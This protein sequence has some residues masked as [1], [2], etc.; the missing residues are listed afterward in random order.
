MTMRVNGEAPSAYAAAK[1]TN[2][3]AAQKNDVAQTER[4]EAP[5]YR[6]EISARGR[7]ESDGEYI[8]RL[9]SSTKRYDGEIKAGSMEEFYTSWRAKQKELTERAAEKN[10]AVLILPE[11]YSDELYWKGDQILGINIYAEHWTEKKGVENPLYAEADERFESY[12]SVIDKVRAGGASAFR[13]YNLK[14]AGMAALANNAYADEELGKRIA[15]GHTTVEEYTRAKSYANEL[16]N[17]AGVFVAVDF[18]SPSTRFA[19]RIRYEYNGSLANIGVKE[20]DFMA[21]HKEASDVWVKA[22][23]GAY[24]N[25]AEIVSALKKSGR[26]DT[27]V[28]YQEFLGGL[29]RRHYSLDEAMRANFSYAHGE[30]WEAATNDA[31]GYDRLQRSMRGNDNASIRYTQ[32]EMSRALS[33][34]VDEIKFLHRLSRQRDP[35]H[36]I[37]TADGRWVKANEAQQSDK[38]A[39]RHD[40]P[41]DQ[42]LANL[43][44]QL[45]E[46]K[47][48]AMSD[49]QKQPLITSIQ[50][51]I[52]TILAQRLSEL[53]AES[54]KNK[55]V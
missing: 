43:R 25:H 4:V 2:A 17:R 10:S 36:L 9:M 6:V 27:A 49:D 20:L 18:S 13:Q 8:A 47:K 46:V 14:F 24:K 3:N 29:T 23:Q 33:D 39:R 11:P 16:Q 31:D 41:L 19:A 48:S 50:N 22:A 15:R 52:N 21:R 12:R 40:N 45:A 42:E 30:L 1:T 5:A 35:L 34:G 38:N 44:K 54:K 51:R 28:A 32:G 26:D 53:T 7:D 55:Y 37:Q